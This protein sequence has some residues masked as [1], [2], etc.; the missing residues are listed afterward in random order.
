LEKLAVAASFGAAA[1]TGAVIG[2]LAVASGRILGCGSRISDLFVFAHQNNLYFNGLS[3]LL[4]NNPQVI[5]KSSMFRSD[6]GARA[7]TSPAT[8]VYT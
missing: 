2:S 7:K 5:D 1:Y 3:A 8:F 6:F 4:V